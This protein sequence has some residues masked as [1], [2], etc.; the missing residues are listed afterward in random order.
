MFRKILSVGGL[1]LA[2]RVLG[3]VRDILTA[4]LLGAGPVADAFFVAFRLPNHFR[5]LFAEGAF[6]AAFVP[7]F[8]SFLV[9]Q[10]RSQARIFA[11]Q[12]L[13]FLL[14]V[15]L[16]LLLAFE[17]I[18]PWF[19][20]VF[21]PGFADEPMKYDLAVLF[22][23]ITFPYL[24]FISLV[25]LMGAVLNSI[26]R[27]A[28]AA[29]APILLNLCLIGALVGL[30]PLL[31]TA[32]HALAWGVLAAGVAQF[33]YLAWDCRRA[34]M[35]L[36]LPRPRLTP[37]VKRFLTVLGP[38]ALGAGVT[39]INLFIDT[40]IASLLPTGSVS[41]L[42]Y[43]D[44]INQ[45]PLGV[46]GI[47]IG[48]V[49]LPELS[50]ALKSGNMQAAGDSQNRAIELSLLFTLPATA[51]FLAA[52][53]PIISVLFERGAFQAADA[54]AT[55]AT[56]MA[57]ALGLPAFVLIR[58]LLPGFY[59][60]ED[61]KTPVKIA[62]VVV[63]VNV[64]LKLAL[65]QPLSQV[66]LALA[67]SAAS[68]VNCALLAVLLFRRGFLVLDAR[69]RRR[70]PRQLL[71]ALAMAGVLLAAQWGLG[72]FLSAPDLWTRSLALG[73]LV[74]AGVAAYAVAGMALGV[75]SMAE[76]KLYTRRRRK[77]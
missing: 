51:A 59:A 60:R 30:T 74:G 19:M 11:E 71:A 52:G 66:G 2:S 7:M 34:G 26:E 64:A 58:S 18:M 45:L 76:L 68:W 46:I 28:A 16:V 44:R 73:A 35:S 14:V 37:G 61:T 40:L 43:A 42:Y 23:R 1:T 53:F 54:Q 41:Y 56:L 20:V 6:N 65:M 38:A 27:F 25:S 70:V 48:T 62:L 50:R 21:A 63:T 57:Y 22:T 17:L 67:T 15:Q 72:G 12:V 32:G 24:L 10:G 31:P 75:V 13:A 8:S 29:A 33:L 47:A 4:A 55:S 39:Q 36:R 3:F 77:G 69:L 49:L 9:G 5:A